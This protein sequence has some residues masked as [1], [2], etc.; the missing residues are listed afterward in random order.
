MSMHV[1]TQWEGGYLQAK[2][3]GLRR[4]NLDL[5]FQPPEIWENTFPSCKPS[6][7]QYF[8]MAALALIYPHSEGGWNF[9][10]CNTHCYSLLTIIN[11]FPQRFLTL[12]FTGTHPVF[13]FHHLHVWTK[14]DSSPF[15]H[16][17]NKFYS[18]AFHLGMHY[19]TP[20]SAKSGVAGPC[21]Q[22]FPE[23]FL[24][25]APWEWPTSSFRPVRTQ[26]CAWNLL[27]TAGFNVLMTFLSPIYH[28]KSV[29]KPNNLSLQNIFRI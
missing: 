17:P 27:E 1:R 15:Q 6:S 11:D 28:I 26:M 12:V 5:D 14:Y 22:E 8:V 29:H 4:T 18:H 21:S 19:F 16:M 2:K 9:S 24:L 25:L 10:K 20:T 13:T 7:L 3:R 23:F